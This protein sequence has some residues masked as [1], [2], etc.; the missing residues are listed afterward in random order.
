MAKMARVVERKVERQKRDKDTKKKGFD[1][2]NLRDW[3]FLKIHLV[4]LIEQQ[5]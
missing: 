5:P 4:K 1:D 3:P 2:E